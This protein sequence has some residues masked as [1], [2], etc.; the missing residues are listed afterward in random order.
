MLKRCG[1]CGA[2]KELEEFSKNKTGKYGRHHTCRTCKSAWQKQRYERAKLEILQHYCNGDIRCQ[3]PGCNV[4]EP[5]FLTIDHIKTD[6]AEHRRKI[7]EGTW[8]LYWWLRKNKFP[9]DFQVLCYNCNCGRNRNNGVCPH[10]LVVPPDRTG[11]VR[12]EVVNM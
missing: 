1:H 11:E 3:C 8:V 10:L 4:R 7:G 9:P 6:G 12:A 2:P 5:L